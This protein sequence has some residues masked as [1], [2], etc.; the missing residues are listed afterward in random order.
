ML[1]SIKHINAPFQKRNFLQITALKPETD[2]KISSSKRAGT[3]I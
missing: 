2:P 3:T 1:F